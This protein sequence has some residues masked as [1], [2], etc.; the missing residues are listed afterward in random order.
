MQLRDYQQTAVDYAVDWANHAERGKR[1]MLAAPT[2]TGKSF[3][4]LALQERIAGSILV[5]PRIEIIDGLLNKIGI[6]SI[7]TTTDWVVEQAERCNIY[8]PIR[9]RNQLLAGE[10]KAPPLL[11]LDEAHHDSA[12]SWQDLHLLCGY[13][14]AVGLTASPFRGT[15]KSTATF[16]REW[17]EPVWVLTF[18][19]AVERNVLSM[20]VCTT[21]PLVDDDLIEVSNGELVAKQVNEAVAGR[22]EAAADLVVNGLEGRGSEWKGPEGKDCFDTPTMFA[23]PSLECVESLRIVLESKGIHGAVVTGKTPYSERQ[24]AFRACLECKA[25][26][27]QVAVVSEGV[28]L[29]IR[30]LIDLSPTLSPV[31]WLQQFGRITR[32]GGHSYYTCTNR[33]LLRHGYLLDGCL[34]PS[35]MQQAQAVFPPSTR[36]MGL[37]AVG[38]ESVGRLKPADIP[39]KGGLKALLYAMSSMEGHKRTDYCVI[40]HPIKEDILWARKDSLRSEQTGELVW[41]KWYRCE[42]PTELTGFASLP[43]QP[44]TDK[45][46][47]WWMRAAASWGLDAGA[48]INKKQFPVLPVLMDLRARL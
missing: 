45:Q 36:S 21:V 22:L 12:E 14:P 47:H 32:P 20:P 1:L 30:R 40:V 28:D 39:L 15:P 43:P 25:V 17:G 7:H 19:E 16:R 10:V 11:I 41:G 33:N 5:S 29:P 23:V 13:P 42:P 2:G 38:L 27:I 4:E 3:V 26:L 44:L 46:K 34:P 18:P 48:K 24:T 6:K 35:A 31:K 8:T 37:R 9:L